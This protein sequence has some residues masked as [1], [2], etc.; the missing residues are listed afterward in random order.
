M[1]RTKTVTGTSQNEEAFNFIKVKQ[2]FH[3]HLNA[4]NIYCIS[5]I[6]CIL[7]KY[8]Q[9]LVVNEWLETQNVW[10]TN[11][12]KHLI[13]GIHDIT[14]KPIRLIIEDY[15]WAFENNFVNHA[16]NIY[17]F[18]HTAKAYLTNEI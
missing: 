13:H 8:D 14:K 1:N 10:T 5:P 3:K 16:Q 11:F 7:Y 12:F 18:R 9:A 2:S 15:I 4:Y 6:A 17:M